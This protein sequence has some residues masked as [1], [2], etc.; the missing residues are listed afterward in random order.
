MDNDERERLLRSFA[1]R[2]KGASPHQI[3]RIFNRF[4]KDG[5]IG[6]DGDGRAVLTGR[7]E[8]EAVH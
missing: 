5:M 2:F 3:E 6:L 1:N 4:V 7:K 8:A